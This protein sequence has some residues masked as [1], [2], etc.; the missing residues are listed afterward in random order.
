[1][2]F[3]PGSRNHIAYWLK[4]KYNWEPLVYTDSGEPQL[5]EDVL[6]SLP[7][8]EASFL[9]EYFLVDKRLGQIAEGEQAWLKCVDAD[10]RIHGYINGN[11]AVTSRMSHSKPNLA[12]VP[13]VGSPYGQECRSLFTAQFGWNLVGIDASGLELR[14]L[15]HYLARYDGGEYVKAILE[16]DI[17]S[18]NMN[19]LGLTDRNKSKTFIYAWLYGAGDEKLGLITDTGPKVGRG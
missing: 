18:F 5:D 1:M 11:G 13:R 8:P 10:G 6:K 14:M 3:N 17:H 15:A 2:E 4:R 16:G 9:L 7:Y 12:Q 19:A